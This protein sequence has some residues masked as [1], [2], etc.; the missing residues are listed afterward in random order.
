MEAVDCTKQLCSIMVDIVELN[1]VISTQLRAIMAQQ[2][3]AD[4]PDDAVSVKAVS[5]RAGEAFYLCSFS[6]DGRSATIRESPSQV[7]GI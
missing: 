1:R 5:V 7:K 6:V 3:T 2:G 4:P